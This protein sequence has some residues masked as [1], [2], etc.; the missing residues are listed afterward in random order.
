MMILDKEEHRGA[1]LQLIRASTFPGDQVE[2][3]Y[4]LQQEIKS[5]IIRNQG[6]P[7]GLRDAQQDSASEGTK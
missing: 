1:L 7:T 6:C 3:V 4:E 2:F 5:A